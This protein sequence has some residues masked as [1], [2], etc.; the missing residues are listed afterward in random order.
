MHTYICTY[1]DTYLLLVLLQPYLADSHGRL[2]LEDRHLRKRRS[3]NKCIYIYMYNSIIC[4]LVYIY[5]YICV[6]V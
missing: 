4:L 6:Y 3:H 5:I 1:Y 2:A